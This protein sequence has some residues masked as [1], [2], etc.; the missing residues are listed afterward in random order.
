MLELI[1]A[2]SG[3]V[4]SKSPE[5]Q[6]SLFS[7]PGSVSCSVCL[8]LITDAGERSFAKLKCGHHFHLDCIGSA[9]NAKGSMQC[10]NCRCVEEGQW[11][12]KNGC[13]SFEDYVV[14]GLSY[15]D[16]FEVYAGIAD[17]FHP[18][19]ELHSSHLHGAAH[20]LL[21]HQHVSVTL[22]GAN[23]PANPN[24]VVNVLYGEHGGSSNPVRTCPYLAAQ[25]VQHLRHMQFLDGNAGIPHIHEMGLHMAGGATLEGT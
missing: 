6:A 18:P 14:D 5:K 22:E 16:D 21:P 8:E 12:F 17:L 11:H 2:D 25:R 15:E 4:M 7:F 13:H 20:S 24:L 10:P 1:M 3:L 9:F 19:E 23:P